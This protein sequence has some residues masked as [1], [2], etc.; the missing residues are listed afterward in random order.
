MTEF[1]IGPLGTFPVEPTEFAV[2]VVRRNRLDDATP[3]ADHIVRS[4]AE[5]RRYPQLP[6][7]KDR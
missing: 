7:W 3:L 6:P 1:P 2:L 5:R 4:N